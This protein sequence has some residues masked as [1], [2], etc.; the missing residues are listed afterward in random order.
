MTD[1]SFIDGMLDRRRRNVQRIAEAKAMIEE[2]QAEITT[3]ER[4]QQLVDRL[5]T[6]HDLGLLDDGEA[7][8][9]AAKGTP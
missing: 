2:C 5:L 9:P 7:A 8:A 3:L 1:A 4:Q 6:M